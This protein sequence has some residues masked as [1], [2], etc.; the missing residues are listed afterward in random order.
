VFSNNTLWVLKLC[1]LQIKHE[2]ND[3]RIL[4]KEGDEICWHFAYFK[5]ETESLE[6]T[7]ICYEYT[8]FARW[9]EY[10]PEENNV[11]FKARRLTLKR[12][13]IEIFI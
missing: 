4:I 8:R 3:T 9:E 13:L 5:L 12:W 7:S 10:Y 2:S 1:L 11:L 6:L